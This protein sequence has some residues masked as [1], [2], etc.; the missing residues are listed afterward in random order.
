MNKRIG[1]N[2]KNLGRV[3]IS[4][5]FAFL[6][7]FPGAARAQSALDGFDP[8]AN[9]VVRI[10][11][12]QPDGKILIGGYFTSVLG[13]TRNRIARL[14]ADGTLDTAFNPNANNNVLA[15]AVQADGKILVGGL[16]TSIGGQPRHRIA[17]LNSVTG[18]ADSFDPDSSDYVSTIVV[19]PNGQILAG[20]SFTGIGGATRH[21]I[22][23]LDA[24]T[25]LADSFNPDASDFV[26]AITVQA[27]GKILVGGF[28]TEIG[29]QSRN[30]IARLDAVTGSADSFNPHATNLVNTIAV[31]TDGKIL[32]GGIFNGPNGIGGQ[33]RNYIA[34]L[35]AV[36]GLADTWNPNANGDVDS[37]VVQ[38]DGKILAGGGFNGANSI[39][40]QTRNCIARLDAVTGL[41]D[42]FNPTAN[43]EVISIAVQANGKVLVGGFNTTLAPNG[44]A[45]VTRNYIARVETDGRLDQALDLGIVGSQVN[46]TAIQPD[47]KIIIGGIFSTVL[48]VTRNNLAR[49]NTDG[50]LDAAFDPN[51]NA[52]VYSIALQTDGKILVGGPFTNV[53]GQTRNRIA[54]LDAVTGL[55]DSF[56]PNATDEV[57]SIAVQPDGKILAGGLFT[58]IGSATRNR[59]ARLDAVTG[60]AD[61]F[62]PNS[63][64]RVY[65]IG[66]QTDGKI[67][68]GGQF[69]HIGGQARNRIARL[70]AVTGM[71]DSFDPNCDGDIY[72]IVIQVDG[73]IL[74][75]GRFGHIGGQPRNNIARVD[76]VTGLADSFDPNAAVGLNGVYSMALQ[77]DG[78]VVVGYA[79]TTIGGQ[80]RSCIARLD[81]TTGLA[82]SF[83]PNANFFVYS[84]AV[85]ADGKILA[86]GGFTGANSIGAQTRNAFA[87]L[88]NDT[89]ALQNLAVQPTTVTWTRGGSSPQLTRVLFE[90]STDNMNYTFLGNGTPAANN[91]TLTGLSL[92]TS[93]NLYIRARGYYRSGFLSSSEGVTES[94]RSAFFAPD[95]TFTLSR[96]HQ[97]FAG[98]GGSG[99]VNVTASDPGC[100]WTAS[101][102]SPF[103]TINSG[104]PGMGNGTVQYS[105][106]ANPNS[107]IRNATIII[108]DQTFT[109]YQGINFVDVPPDSVFYTE[110]GKLSARGVTLGC[111]NGNYCPNDLVLRDQMAAFI[112]RA[113][114]EFSPPTPMTQRFSDVPPGNVFYNFIDRLAVLQITLGCSPTLYCPS[115][116]VKREQMAAFI[117][118][119]LGEFNPPTPPMQRFTDVPPESPFY[120]FIDRM[121]VLQIT[122]GCSPALYCP[123]DIVTRGQMA[124]FLVRAFNL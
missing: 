11:V 107:T 109:V 69:S 51:A 27:D 20:G 104:T 115:D 49:L 56:D 39:G 84:V 65:T 16:F 91:W 80:T 47:G 25:G 60:L 63:D 64:G 21:R 121:A 35:D 112:V 36:S 31:Q 46:S 97:S 57:D 101:T 72:A 55:A 110:I 105:V 50:T 7:C 87:R 106:A 76:G 81:A 116:P 38:A 119:G 24:T 22:A 95:C 82:D 93:Q 123:N 28:F 68:V 6:L 71:A 103:I 113:K 15:I 48:G 78:K 9:D 96:D 117:I 88:S 40:G 41:A 77:A 92:P 74:E 61:S 102:T 111:G 118:R 62:N 53:G 108:G 98:N 43:N 32:A 18:V 100:A 13:V 89:A 3:S 79:G 42:S 33:T 52:N 44:G 59:I 66:V 94:V 124:A 45:P 37:I 83:D 34:R 90:S 29:G 19:Q 23:R 2:R 10:V 120:K 86:G 5:L 26:R 8:N 122:L 67:L 75:C 1:S 17:R 114:G 70:D 14:N 4:A 99:T 85:Q 58:N 30:C 54:R 73:Q 12:V